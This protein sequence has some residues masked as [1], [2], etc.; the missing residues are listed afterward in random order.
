MKRTII[1]KVD[2]PSP[3]PSLELISSA[4]DSLRHEPIDTINWPA[5][6]YKPELSFS[7]GYTEDELL[8]KF[9]VREKEILAERTQSNESVCTD[10]CVELFFSPRPGLYY[11]LE[12]NCIGTMLVGRG[13]CRA[14][15]RVID[16]AMIA[17]IRR[18]SSLG[19]EPFEVKVGDFEWNLVEAIPLSLLELPSGSELSGRVFRANLFKCA[20]N[21]PTPHFVT[22][23]PI[24]TPEPDYHQPDF[25]GEL[26]FE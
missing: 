19:S 4:L 9:R 8:L 13:S 6:P 18:R 22:W 3:Q 20:E 23:S 17:R 1:S 26:E 25:F 14:D 15:S 24:D 5:F 10:C 11:N 12:C 21:T 7:L 2:L 16:P